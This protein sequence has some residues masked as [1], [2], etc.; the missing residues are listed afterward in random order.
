MASEALEARLRG[1]VKEA[2]EES[3]ARRAELHAV[4]QAGCRDELATA[5]A[6]LRAEAAAGAPRAATAPGPRNHR[7]LC[8][9]RRR[10]WA[11]LG[12]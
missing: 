2:A 4:L 7:A 6:G 1:K 11:F 8:A 12:F 9:P 10:F 3:A 5:S